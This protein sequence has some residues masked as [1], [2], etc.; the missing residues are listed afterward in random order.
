[1]GTIQTWKQDDLTCSKVLSCY[2]RYTTK[3]K[4]RE[5][6]NFN[7]LQHEAL[8]GFEIE[9]KILHER[10]SD[11]NLGIEHEGDL[12]CATNSTISKESNT[13]L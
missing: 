9:D 11:N 4:R 12:T 8:G 10:D 5:K 3:H 2:I 7:T 1:M 13:Y 6:M